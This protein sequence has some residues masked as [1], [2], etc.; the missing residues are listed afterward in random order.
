LTT[1]PHQPDVDGGSPDTSE[2]IPAS[3]QASPEEGPVPE[4]E[5]VSVQVPVQTAATTS[6]VDDTHANSNAGGGGIGTGAGGG[7]AETTTISANDPTAINGNLEA[8]ATGL[9]RLVS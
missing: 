3:A 7:E 5:P 6:S 2:A 4:L 8:L 1:E 9:M